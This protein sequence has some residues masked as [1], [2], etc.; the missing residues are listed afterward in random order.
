[1][2]E[3]L[4]LVSQDQLTVEAGGIRRSGASCDRPEEEELAAR[5]DPPVR[6]AAVHRVRLPVRRLLHVDRLRLRHPGFPLVVV[7]LHRR[8]V[9]I[10]N[11]QARGGV[12]TY[13]LLLPFQ[14]DGQLPAKFL[15]HIEH[16]LRFV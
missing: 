5:L 15:P 1:M 8:L 12:L 11:G 4:C 7:E 16:F 9:E 3:V 10:C 2:P 6:D 13:D 14:K